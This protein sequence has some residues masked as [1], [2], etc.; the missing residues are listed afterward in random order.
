MIFNQT[1]LYTLYALLA[2]SGI[3]CVQ[4]K[5]VF[6][7]LPEGPWRG[8]LLLDRTP[9]V[10]YGDDRDIKKSFDFDS[11]LPFTFTLGRDEKDSLYVEFE[12]A[13]EKI[14]NYHITTGKANPT[15]KDTV[16]IDFPTYDTHLIAVY[17][18]GV[19]EGNWVV[20]YKENYMI[21]FKAVY[22]QNHRFIQSRPSEDSLISGQWKMVFEPETPD[23]YP[24]IGLFEQ[25]GNVVTGTVLTETGDY[26][27]LAGNIIKDKVYLSAF[28]GAHAFLIQGKLMAKDSMAGSFRSGKH[29]TAT[30]LGNRDKNFHLQ[31]A[32]SITKALNTQPIHFSFLN[33]EGHRVSLDSAAWSGKLKIIQVMG[34]WCPNCLDE[35]NMIKAYFAKNNP[36]DI[37]WI[38]LAFER[39][40]EQEKAL[41]Q[42]KKYKQDQ[43]LRHEIL[44]GGLYKKEEAAKQL[45][46]I[47][48]FSAYPT[49][50]ILDSE[51]K[52]RHIHTGFS[53][54]ATREYDSFQTEFN[55]I[56]ESLS[57][58]KK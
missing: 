51:N 5:T 26:R 41:A 2:I 3:A 37:V 27:Y 18:D 28:D 7:S 49:L 39:Y 46:F 21:P 55:H 9:V 53:G 22:G 33:T 10:T 20:R 29:Y 36:E 30:W 47:T 48:G 52:I 14:R 1:F 25:V 57:N 31:D 13:R 56:L 50:L 34:T 15:S 43:D 44:W 11:E 45:P 8:V 6:E 58:E 4:P 42:L 38:S 19:M 40:P 32:F 24:G 54:P 12:N 16:R 17:E 35:T 23:A